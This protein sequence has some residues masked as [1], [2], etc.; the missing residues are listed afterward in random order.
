MDE[1]RP[2]PAG[3]IEQ[4]GRAV[5]RRLASLAKFLGFVVEVGRGLRGF[6]RSRIYAGRVLTMQILF[7]G[8]EA[9]AVVAVLSLALGAVI[10]VQGLSLLP[11][12]GQGDL[13]YDILIIV[14]TRELGPILTAFI[15]TARSGTAIATELGNMVVN[16]EIEAY[17]AT[18]INPIAYVVVPRV[19][20]VVFSTVVLNFYFNVFGLAGSYMVTQLLGSI[21]LSEYSA[22]LLQA[23][24]F[25]DIAV[26]L[27][28]SLVFGLLISLLATYHGLQVER[29]SYEVPVVVIKA[30][31]QGFVLS[32]LANAIITV[33]SYVA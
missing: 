10:I 2:R 31:T 3:P 33:I 18:G 14:I 26:S 4:S 30:V 23:L 27:T 7:T 12:F 9:L 20:G 28:K 13:I 11:Q 15:I 16:H 25:G 17:T 32:I 5:I 29:A 22:G 1:P 6:L 24:S 19:L 21:P 8:V